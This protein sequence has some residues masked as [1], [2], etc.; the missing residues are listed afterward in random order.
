VIGADAL[1]AALAA[2][3]DAFARGDAPAGAAAVAAAEV[4][5]G[6]LQAAGR[7]LA[8]GDLARARALHERGARAAAEARD[9]AAAGLDDAASARRAVA[10]YRR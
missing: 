7:P 5:C 1:L 2:A 3:D 9:R 8:P 6:A 4:V 10:A